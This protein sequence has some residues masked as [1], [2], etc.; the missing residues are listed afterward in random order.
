MLKSNCFIDTSCKVGDIAY[1]GIHDLAK[2]YREIGHL[3]TLKLF[4]IFDKKGEIVKIDPISQTA[5]L[6]LE[7]TPFYFGYRKLD[8]DLCATRK[9]LKKDNRLEIKL[10]ISYLEAMTSIMEDDAIPVFLV[11]DGNTKYQKNLMK[12]LRNKELQRINKMMANEP[13]ATRHYDHLEGDNFSFDDIDDLK[14]EQIK[15]NFDPGI[16]SKSRKWKYFISR[17]KYNYYP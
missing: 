12:A 17:K 10:P 4:D 16:T 13:P 14:E 8:S 11:I 5:T 2:K 1:F 3:P 9:Y 15:E 7:K 6:V